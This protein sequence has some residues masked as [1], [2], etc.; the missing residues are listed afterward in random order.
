[1]F[2]AAP[3]IAGSGQVLFLTDA[4]LD[5]SIDEVD[6]AKAKDVN[7]EAPGMVKLTKTPSFKLESTVNKL[8][9]TSLDGFLLSVTQQDNPENAFRFDPVQDNE[10]LMNQDYPSVT[11]ANLLNSP[12]AKLVALKLISTE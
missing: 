4:G 6:Q 11:S 1:M 2:A 7:I 8:D 5:N 12:F 3:A 10:M 9:F